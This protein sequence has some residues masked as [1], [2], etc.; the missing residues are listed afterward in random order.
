[1]YRAN[2]PVIFITTDLLQSKNVA[3]QIYK[4]DST[5]SMWPQVSERC[6]PHADTTHKYA[7]SYIVVISFHAQAYSQN[8][9]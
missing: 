2:V 9:V 3:P 1:M 6:F 8:V 4:I 5:P 7:C